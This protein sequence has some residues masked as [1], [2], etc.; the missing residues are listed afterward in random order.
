MYLRDSIL[1]WIEWHEE[2][3][4]FCVL[5]LSY[6]QGWTGQN[7]VASIYHEKIDILQNPCEIIRFLTWNEN[8]MN[9]SCMEIT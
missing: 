3:I 7:D 6:F 2:K 5:N 1:V 9:I 4:Y 8:E